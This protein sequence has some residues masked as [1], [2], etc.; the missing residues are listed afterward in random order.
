MVEVYIRGD[1]TPGGVWGKRYPST[2][3]EGTFFVACA[4]PWHTDISA[5][6]C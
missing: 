4:V 6:I 3:R 2:P 1:Y 5:R